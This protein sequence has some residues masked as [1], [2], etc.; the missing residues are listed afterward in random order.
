MSPASY[1]N[2]NDYLQSLVLRPDQMPSGWSAYNYMIDNVLDNVQQ[3]RSAGCGSGSMLSVPPVV[4]PVGVV[5]DEDDAKLY[6]VSGGHAPELSE[7]FATYD[8]PALTFGTI[9]GNLDDCISLAEQQNPIDGGVAT[10]IDGIMKRMSAP[11]YGAESVA[12]MATVGEDGTPARKGSSWPA[13]GTR[14]CS[15]T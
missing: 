7:I 2:V 3:E 13:R 1:E 5:Y 12:Y 14:S 8:N 15:S 4:N 10:T 6:T 9:K 11:K